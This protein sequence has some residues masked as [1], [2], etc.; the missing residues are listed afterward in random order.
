MQAMCFT[1][2]PKHMLWENTCTVHA[3]QV[4]EI[5]LSAKSR[6]H[7]CLFGQVWCTPST[8]SFATELTHGSGKGSM[9]S[10]RFLKTKTM[11]C[12]WIGLMFWVCIC[13]CRT[14][15]LHHV[16]LQL[17]Q[18]ACCTHTAF[19]TLGTSSLNLLVLNFSSV[20]FVRLLCFRGFAARC[21]ILQSIQIQIGK[22][23]PVAIAN[24]VAANHTQ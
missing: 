10:T 2:R 11:A 1:P 15:I 21:P 20:A 5:I 22:R 24:S 13:L 7:A 19:F 23:A 18:A 6:P 9:Y 14:S 8:S 12:R 16:E 3:F 17:Q 4:Q